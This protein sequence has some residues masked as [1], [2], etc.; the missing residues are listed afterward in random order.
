[1]IDMLHRSRSS[2]LALLLM[3][4]VASPALA[5]PTEHPE[6]RS[7]SAAPSA[8]SA[9]E[10][11]SIRGVLSKAPSYAKVDLVDIVKA[12][13]GYLATCDNAVT[14]RHEAR[15]RLHGRASGPIRRQEHLPP[16]DDAERVHEDL[17]RHQATA[18]TAMAHHDSA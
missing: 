15:S 12:L 18:R 17:Q 6:A 9:G 3:C 16:Y 14:H 11:D 4:A 1:V 7:V 10:I 8:L 5:S 2:T 13:S